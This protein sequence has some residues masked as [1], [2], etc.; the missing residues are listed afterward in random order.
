M[1]FGLLF[2]IY[3]LTFKL[4]FISLTWILC[5]T[6][7]GLILGLGTSFVARN[8]HELKNV[9]VLPEADLPLYH[10]WLI[11]VAA[12][13][14]TSCNLHAGIEAVEDSKSGASGLIFLYSFASIFCFA[15]FVAVDNSIKAREK[16]SQYLPATE[17]TW[18]LLTLLLSILTAVSIA[19]VGGV[20]TVAYCVSIMLT[21]SYIAY[22]IEIFGLIPVIAVGIASIVVLC[23][24][25]MLHRK[26]RRTAYTLRLLEDMESRHLT[27]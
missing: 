24:M 1:G 18:T 26:K 10:F 11:G 21:I 14:Y 19:Q 9:L 20:F 27:P 17:N 15:F 6:F 8:Y 22:S 13:G 23:G 16:L 3:D 25:Y 12:G 2:T 5:G 4:R 7:V